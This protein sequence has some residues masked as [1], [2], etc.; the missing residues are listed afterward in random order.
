MLQLCTVTWCNGD[1]SISFGFISLLL[2][3][4][5]RFIPFFLSIAASS[6]AAAVGS[7]NCAALDYIV[8]GHLLASHWECLGMCPLLMVVQPL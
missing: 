7:N 6:A 4:L 8:L 5:H 3:S 2:I 1:H